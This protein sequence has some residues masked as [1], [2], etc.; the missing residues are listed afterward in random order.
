MEKTN[1]LNSKIKPPRAR[2]LADHLAIERATMGTAEGNDLHSCLWILTGW[3]QNVTD[4]PK[5]TEVPLEKEEL[6]SSNTITAKSAGTYLL[7]S[8]NYLCPQS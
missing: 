4:E 2:I 3:P 7:L 5:E 8:H 6:T 1:C